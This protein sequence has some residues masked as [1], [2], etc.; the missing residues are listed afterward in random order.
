MSIAQMRGILIAGW[1]PLAKLMSYVYLIQMSEV[2][3]SQFSSLA[4]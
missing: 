1:I 2:I 4:N 3:Y